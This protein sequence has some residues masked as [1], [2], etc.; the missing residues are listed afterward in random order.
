[1][2]ERSAESRGVA[3][4]R[5]LVSATLELLAEL[6]YEALTMDAVA[7]RA[8]ASKATIYRR[9]SGKAELV[10]HAMH[11]HV[12]EQP[13]EVAETG[14]L[15]E[16]LLGLLDTIRERFNPTNRALMLGLLHAS[17][18]DPELGALIRS[19]ITAQKDALAELLARRV[20]AAGLEPPNLELLR[21]VGGSGIAVRLL[22]TGEPVDDEYLRRTVDDVLL[23]LL[24]RTTETE[25][26]R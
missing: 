23:P 19:V 21:D 17:Q 18:E 9:W 2:P 25:C 24:T 7:A 20:R 14:D 12:A 1:M 22:L 13:F 4:E 10:M 16:D 6:G 3:R 5:A 11:A 8:H 26:P 15:R